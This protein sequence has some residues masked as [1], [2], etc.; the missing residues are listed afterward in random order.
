MNTRSRRVSTLAKLTFAFAA[1]AVIAPAV[2]AGVNTW[3]GT[4]PAEGVTESPGLVAADPRDPYVVYAV[5]QPNLYKSRDGGRSWTRIA[6]VP[7]DPILCWCIPPRRQ[8]YAGVVDGPNSE[9]AGVV[10]SSDGGL[11]WVSQTV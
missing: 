3:S 10:K 2:P 8:L 7:P 5:F 4:F 9:F 11:T 6:A 1:M